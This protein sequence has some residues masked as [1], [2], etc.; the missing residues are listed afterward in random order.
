LLGTLRLKKVLRVFQR[1]SPFSAVKIAVLSQF[2]SVSGNPLPLEWS[3]S[4]VYTPEWHSQRVISLFIPHFSF[5]FLL[6][7]SCIEEKKCKLC[8]ILPYFSEVFASEIDRRQTIERHRR[9]E[10]MAIPKSF[11]KWGRNLHHFHFFY[12]FSDAV[13]KKTWKNRGKTRSFQGENRI[14]TMC[15]F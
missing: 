8:N 1:F 10:Y 7:V 3:I 6:L 5:F 12:S 14:K 13:K 4:V 9:E 2:I 11:Q 15:F